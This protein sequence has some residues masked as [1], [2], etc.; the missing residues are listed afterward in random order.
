MFD[1]VAIPDGNCHRHHHR[2][3]PG[4]DI[5]DHVASGPGLVSSGRATQTGYYGFYG[6]SPNGRFRAT[7]RNSY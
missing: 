7:F 3:Q 5:L 2:R 1:P 6:Y 4:A